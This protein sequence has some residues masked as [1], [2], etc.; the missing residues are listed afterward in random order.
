MTSASTGVP[1]KI[2]YGSGTIAGFVFKDSVDIAGFHIPEQALGT[3]VEQSNTFADEPFDGI[4]GLGFNDLST[5]T[6]RTILDHLK[7]QGSIKRKIFSLFLDHIDGKPSELLLGAVNPQRYHGRVTRFPIANNKGYWSLLLSGVSVGLNKNNANK[8][9]LTFAQNEAIFDSGTSLIIAPKGAAQKLHAL[10]PGSRK[11]YSLRNMYTFPCEHVQNLKIG[12][13]FS[14]RPFYLSAEDVVM[15]TL[16]GGRTCVSSIQDSKDPEW[17]LGGS[18][19]RSVYSV[20]DADR[21]AIG[22]ARVKK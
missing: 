4:L 3:V 9:T 7:E 6:A 14:G 2:Q 19:L 18:F 15:G 11:S 13:V 8:T 17:I 12:F 16:D 1:F 5:Y 21:R 20:F 22:L 10:I